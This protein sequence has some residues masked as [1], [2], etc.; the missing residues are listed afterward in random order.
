M[1]SL[2]SLTAFNVLASP[3]DF[4][5]SKLLTAQSLPADSLP[6]PS[7]DRK[8]LETVQPLTPG[9]IISPGGYSLRYPS[10]WRRFI[11][12]E[13]NPDSDVFIA[14]SIANKPEAPLATITTTIRDLLVVPNELPKGV[15]K[16]SQAAATYV[17]ILLQSGY[18]VS[19]VR[20]VV[21]NGRPG[22]KVV[23]ETPDK[24]GSIALLIDGDKEK[25][26][27][28]TAVYPI[29]ASVVTPQLLEPVITEI[30]SIQ[31][32]ITILRQK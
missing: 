4:Q 15:T 2:I 11:T 23:S 30:E 8:P 14:R 10:S 16:F 19:D 12:Q 6:P 21:I 25:M 18:K 3:V 13:S 24:R 22:V 28:S 1:W 9:Q 31:N 26:I 27:V 17:G 7:A 5:S 32:S 20:E 29:D